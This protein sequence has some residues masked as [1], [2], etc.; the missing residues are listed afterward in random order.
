MG[1]LSRQ[2]AQGRGPRGGTYQGKAPLRRIEDRWWPS[3]DPRDPGL[4]RLECGH[5]ITQK[6]DLIGPTNATRRRCWKCEA[7]DP[8]DQ[9]ATTVKDED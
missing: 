4:E 9:P 2:R 8:V 1:T 3:S 5:V 7:G 6:C